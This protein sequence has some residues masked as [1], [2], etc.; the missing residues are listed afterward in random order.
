MEQF[1]T[2]TYDDKAAG[3]PTPYISAIEQYKKELAKGIPE[4]RD[5]RIKKQTICRIL[6]A[7][8]SYEPIIDGNPTLCYDEEQPNE[9]FT[10]LIMGEDWSSLDGDC[11][12]IE[13]YKDY[14]N[15]KPTIIAKRDSV[16]LCGY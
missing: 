2:Q 6:N 11:L 7:H 8:C 13:G 4:C 14:Y 1:E 10:L 15:G 3:T 12:V 5:V 16:T 9:K